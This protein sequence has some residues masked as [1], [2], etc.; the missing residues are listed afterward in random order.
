MKAA[1][2][3]VRQNTGHNAINHVNFFSQA[4]RLLMAGQ[5]ARAPPQIQGKWRRR[6]AS[7]VLRQGG[8]KTKRENDGDNNKSDDQQNRPDDAADLASLGGAAPAG[9]HGASVHFFEVAGSHDPGRDG[10][11]AANDQAEDAEDENKC[12]AMWFHN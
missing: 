4:N 8:G 7:V 10:Q 9:V 6:T 5:L 3:G 1:C 11:R 2:A 12:A